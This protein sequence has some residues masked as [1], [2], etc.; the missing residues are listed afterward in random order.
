M[1]N[2][3]V[4]PQAVSDQAHDLYAA[5]QGHP[6]AFLF[7]SLARVTIGTVTGA[8]K[9][10]LLSES[11]RKSNSIPRQAVMPCIT[12]FR[13]SRTGLTLQEED[14]YSAE[15]I[16]E[17]THLFCPS[18]TSK[19]SKVLAYIR[20]FPEEQIETNCTFKKRKTWFR[21]NVPPIPDAFLRYMGNDGPKL[22]L[23]EA[24][25][26]SS[27][28]IHQVNFTERIPRYQARAI[29]LS[30]RSSIS[31]LSAEFVGRT[32]GSGIL[33][34]EP[35]DCHNILIMLPSCNS[36]SINSIWHKAIQ[37]AQRDSHQKLTDLIDHWI[38]ESI[39]SSALP[40]IEEVK[41]LLKQARRR[42]TSY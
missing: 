42:R 13:L 40:S 17:I 10:F 4:V 8:N 26:T 30:I 14:F 38:Y 36:K 41:T 12:R 7:G 28:T 16:G 39:E 27:N 15:R 21:P 35:S 33:K 6:N 34:L 25:A 1:I 32:Y 20:T 11:D 3:H 9:F 37:I 31:Q 5:L 23:N 19:N 22:A 29:A 18:S 24:Q 2:G